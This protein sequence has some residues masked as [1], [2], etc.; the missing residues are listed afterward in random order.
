M[1][2]ANA[3]AGHSP[4]GLEDGGT[5]GWS[6]PTCRTIGW[7]ED[8][9]RSC[10][11]HIIVARELAPARLR[12]DRKILGPLRPKRR[13]GPAGA[14]SLATVVFATL[15]LAVFMESRIKKAGA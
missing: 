8:L 11:T 1:K 9:A 5:P 3:I 14:S 2:R 7:E 12:S 6:A 15:V 13:T 10:L 4:H